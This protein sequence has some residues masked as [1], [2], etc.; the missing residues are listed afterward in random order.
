MEVADK[1]QWP[2]TN[3]VAWCGNYEVRFLLRVG[4]DLWMVQRLD[5]ML[6]FVINYLSGRPIN[7]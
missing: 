3:L 6:I 7:E 1:N 5:T 4:P 2:H